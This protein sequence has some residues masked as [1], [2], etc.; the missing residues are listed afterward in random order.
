M[1]DVPPWKQAI[2]DRRKR[3]E[4]E[5]KRRKA[6]DD[7]YLASL[8]PW[9]RALLL[10]QR[11]KQ[12]QADAALLADFDKPKSPVHVAQT[13]KKEAPPAPRGAR[14]GNAVAASASAQPRGSASGS[15]YTHVKTNQPATPAYTSASRGARYTSP[16]PPAPTGTVSPPR[17]TSV[18]VLPE[19]V[20]GLGVSTSAPVRSHG[21]ISLRPRPARPAVDIQEKRRSFEESE[22]PKLANMPAWKKALIL[23]R[24]A[25]QGSQSSSAATKQDVQQNRSSPV[26]REAE[27]PPTSISTSRAQ[28]RAD[29]KLNRRSPSPL[30]RG[31]SPIPRETSPAP[32][33]ASPVPRRETS[34]TPWREQ[35]P[36]PGRASPVP[37]RETSPTPWREQSPVPGRASPV[38]RREQSPVPGRASPVHRREQS[39]VPRQVSPVHNRDISP[40]PRREPSPV[41]GRASPVPRRE[42]SPNPWREVSPPPRKETSPRP[43]PEALSQSKPAPRKPV[44]ESVVLLHSRSLTSS[45]PV[46][47]ETR[48]LEEKPSTT[49]TASSSKPQAKK[50]ARSRAKKNSKKDRG[51][52]ESGGI[53]LLSSRR[54]GSPEPQDLPPAPSTTHERR[55]AP[56]GQGRRPAPPPPPPSKPPQGVASSTRDTRAQKTTVPPASLRTKPQPEIVNRQSQESNLPNKLVEQ[57]GITLHPPVFKEVDVW[58]N[59]SEDDP[60]FLQLPQWKQALIKRRRADIVKRTTSPPPTSP[61]PDKPKHIH[62]QWSPRNSLTDSRAPE[63]PQ[64]K[65]DLLKRQQTNKTNA[66]RNYGLDRSKPSETK[67]VSVTSSGGVRALLDKF[68]KAPP[69]PRPTRIQQSPPRAVHVPWEDK[70]ETKIVTV[71]V[72]PDEG[73]S[74]SD[75]S[76][77]DIDEIPLTN[78]DELS[79]DEMDDEDSGIST[80]DGSKP[81]KKRY[82]YSLL[83]ES[84]TEPVPDT[85]TVPSAGEDDDEL[86]GEIREQR[87]PSILIDTDNKP[88]KVR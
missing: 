36:V 62:T 71:L 63:L 41:P 21:P 31:T 66:P 15:S 51:G 59:V 12:Q 35:S 17:R 43:I 11:E 79:S 78:I 24:R 9:K 28:H 19:D 52:D 33:R 56:T 14:G 87:R 45:E 57:E 16:P 39:P 49:K 86:T 80:K 32:G 29:E 67:P 23:K 4:E 38:H 34:P 65:L 70:N 72:S 60:K 74:T 81:G 83:P 25:A 69:P 48:Q 82:S 3:Q 58:A 73:D 85:L 1:S 5:E 2:F 53:V 76:D 7:A 88:T 54:I 8:P 50:A 40:T 77:D 42:T 27:D 30:Q 22:D 61:P 6:Q 68:N 55:A 18:T 37:R 26:G 64:W 44:D 46:L 84:P 13:R 47:A 20:S 10:K 75:S